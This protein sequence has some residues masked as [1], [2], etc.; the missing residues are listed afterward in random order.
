M[1]AECRRAAR[2]SL[3]SVVTAGQLALAR[4]LLTSATTDASTLENV[5]GAVVR[6][7]GA[8]LDVGA[9]VA[10]VAVTPGVSVGVTVGVSAGV[11]STDSGGPEG[12]VRSRIACDEP[13]G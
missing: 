7:D 13:T 6:R 10:G 4:S 2:A 5:G 8:V 12:A 3:L 1:S 9:P 11:A